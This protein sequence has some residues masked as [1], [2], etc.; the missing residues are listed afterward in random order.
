MSQKLKLPQ[1][2]IDINKSFADYGI[3]SV[4]AVELA[5][6]LQEYLNYPHPIEATIAWNFP[7]IESLSNYL[8]QNLP[9][10]LT[11]NLIKPTSLDNQPLFE[12]PTAESS[13]LDAMSD[14]ELAQLLVA[15]INA[16]QG[17]ENK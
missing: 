12:P 11:P 1:S 8:A 5:Q 15:E 10:N 17:R 16:V 9:Q 6:D 14:V 3:D 2:A 7:T 4:I 13:E